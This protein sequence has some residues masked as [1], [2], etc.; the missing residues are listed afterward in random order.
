MGLLSAIRNNS[1]QASLTAGLHNDMF[2]KAI[3]IEDK[4]V[5]GIVTKKNCF[6]KF[7]KLNQKTGGIIG[8]T[9]VSWF[10]LDF[11]SDY[12]LEN[13][14]EQL[15]Q[16]V[17]ILEL[18]YTPEEVD[19]QFTPLNG[20]TTYD[21]FK[22]RLTTKV[23]AKELNEAINANISIMLEPH[24]GD[25]TKLFRLKLVYDK[26]GKYLQT[27]QYGDFVEALDK[28]DLKITRTELANETLAK[29]LANGEVSTKDTDID[30][31]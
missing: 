9:E 14:V 4:K 10:R 8:E 20:I 21:E 25:V 7:A 26:N 30:D 16:M 24:C 29:S 18:F 2:L 22:A 12:V 15:A 1:R 13:A 19:E 3:N 11:N 17:S 27:S 31:L 23:G 6:I 28:T 5:N